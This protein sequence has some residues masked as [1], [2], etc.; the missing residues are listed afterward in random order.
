M[1]LTTTILSP[2]HRIKHTI[3]HANSCVKMPCDITHWNECSCMIPRSKKGRRFWHT[4]RHDFQA[5]SLLCSENEL[6]THKCKQFTKMLQMHANSLKHFQHLLWSGWSVLC[7]AG[8]W[9]SQLCWGVWMHTIKAKARRVCSCCWNDK[10]ICSRLSDSLTVH[11][12]LWLHYALK[13]FT[14][15]CQKTCFPHPCGCNCNHWNYFVGHVFDRITRAFL[16]HL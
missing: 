6:Q 4:Y 10:M 7:F 1:C 16:F 2:S 13:S 9:A 12:S 5:S 8:L 15:L 3:S 11:S 14:V